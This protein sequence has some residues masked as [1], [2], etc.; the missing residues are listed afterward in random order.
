MSRKCISVDS[1]FRQSDQ[2]YKL[3]G[4]NEGKKRLLYICVITLH[5]Y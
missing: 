3:D 2:K 4:K 1:H 5:E